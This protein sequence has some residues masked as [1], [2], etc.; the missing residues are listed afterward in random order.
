MAKGGGLFCEGF[1]FGLVGAPSCG[2]FDFYGC[3]FPR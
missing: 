3:E 1:L 2:G